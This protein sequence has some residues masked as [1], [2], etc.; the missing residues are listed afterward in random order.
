M[1]SSS[2][3]GTAALGTAAGAL[4][5]IA[6]FAEQGQIVA[7]LITSNRQVQNQVFSGATDFERVLIGPSWILPAS[8]RELPEIQNRSFGWLRRMLS[9]HRQPS[10]HGE[11]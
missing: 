4:N 1:R 2:G 5:L 11:N 9:A 10:C 7:A 8:H 3:S 6:R